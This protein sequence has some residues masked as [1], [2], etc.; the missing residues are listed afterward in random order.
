MSGPEPEDAPSLA[1]GAPR[2]SAW[3]SLLGQ[4]SSGS[5]S[6]AGAFAEVRGQLVRFFE[7]RRAAVAE[8]LADETLERVAQKLA[9]GAPIGDVRKYLFG[10][11]RFVALEA[12]RRAAPLPAAP[13]DEE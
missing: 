6:H 2:A 4:L 5:R 7:W 3:D 11:A 10:V 13:S 8:D 9:T 1:T 12:S